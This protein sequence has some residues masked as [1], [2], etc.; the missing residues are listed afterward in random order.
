MYHDHQQKKWGITWNTSLKCID[1]YLNVW[2]YTETDVKK[3]V[4]GFFTS[5]GQTIDFS[6]LCELMPSGG[7]PC[8]QG[9]IAV[10]TDSK[11]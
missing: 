11:N 1:L 6:F 5:S 10:L 4:L 7:E 3:K 9:Q 8:D 2:W